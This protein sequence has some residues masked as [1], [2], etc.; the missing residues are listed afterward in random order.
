MM[1][2]S[3]SG[4]VRHAWSVVLVVALVMPGRGCDSPGIHR[5]GE[6]L[7]F[8]LPYAESEL[9]AGRIVSPR[10]GAMRFMR[11]SRFAAV[12]GLVA[13]TLIAASCQEPSWTAFSPSETVGP[14]GGFEFQDGVVQRQVRVSIPTDV[15][16][17]A[18]GGS[19]RLSA[20]T[21]SAAP[22][23]AVEFQIGGLM[24][25][26]AVVDEQGSVGFDFDWDLPKDCEH[27]CDVVLPVTIR[28]VGE[29]DPPVILWS[30]AV[31][32]EYR[33]VSLIPPEA[34]DITAVIEAAVD[35]GS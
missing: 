20:S 28:H 23:S 6:P 24:D 14:S 17:E 11:E 27:G 26:E 16:G 25:G 3:D 22:I 33:S 21:R 32:V 1:S 15:L 18:T 9:P 29:G 8:R 35:N 7:R 10:E 12:I 19:V 5:Q 13:L 4:L 34:Q 2:D 31:S 30:L